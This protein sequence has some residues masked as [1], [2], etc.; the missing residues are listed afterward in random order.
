[1]MLTKEVPFT[2]LL[3]VSGGLP[4]YT[5]SATGLPAGLS[6]D[7]ST[8]LISGKPSKDAQEREY[9]ATVTVI[10]K[11]KLTATGVVRLNL[12]GGLPEDFAI[13]RR[14]STAVCKFG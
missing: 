2:S 3:S 1:M 11:N 8:G 7:A 9:R 13:S 10:D 14:N 4:P 12:V 5:W 6:L